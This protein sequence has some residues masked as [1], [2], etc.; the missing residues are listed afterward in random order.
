[1]KNLKT[2]KEKIEIILT[3]DCSLKM[4]HNDKFNCND[5]GNKIKVKRASNIEFN[6]ILQCWEIKSAKTKKIIK[7]N[8]KTRNQALDYEKKYFS[9]K[10]SNKLIES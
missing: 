8:F 7:S 1:M 5:F 4:L 10:N 6:N 9:F 3:N 2:I